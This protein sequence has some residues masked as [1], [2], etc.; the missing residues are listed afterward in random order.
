LSQE[1]AQRHIYAGPRA[2]SFLEVYISRGAVQFTV[3]R[4]KKPDRNKG[5]NGYGKTENK[6]IP[7]SLVGTS[8][9]SQI[10]NA[11]DKSGKD[12]KS[13]DPGR[14][15]AV[16][17]GEIRRR[18]ISLEKEQPDK[19]TAGYITEENCE[20]DNIHLFIPDFL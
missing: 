2:K 13:D 8:R 3:Q 9:K 5:G 14:N 17:Q 19:N 10:T 12:R 18:L 11:T 16:S 15:L 7:I 1:V 20:I 6:R 4:N